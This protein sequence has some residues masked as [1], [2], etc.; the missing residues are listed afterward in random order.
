MSKKYIYFAT[1]RNSIRLF[2]AKTICLCFAGKT[3]Q[4]QKQYIQTANI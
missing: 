4:L 3:R 2:E 1:K